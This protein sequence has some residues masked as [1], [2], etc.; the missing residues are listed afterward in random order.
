M[1]EVSI[2]IPTYNEKGNITTLLKRI[3]LTFRK[4][5][6]K[7]EVI[8]VDDNSPD[9]TG[10]IAEKLKKK[11]KNL[12]VLQRKEK[13]GLS[14]A[15]LDGLKIMQGKI[16]GVM[17]ADLSHSPEKI[18][19]MLDV[20]KNE[21]ADF[22]IGS[23]YV[24]GGGIVGWNFYRRGVSKGANF[25]SRLVTSV[26]DS[27]S[28]FFLIKN[29]CIQGIKFNPKGFKICLEFIV[30]AKYNKIIEVPFV[31]KDR[32][33]GKSKLSFKEYYNY[34]K[35]LFGLFCYK[36]PNLGQLI[37]FCMVGGVG[38]IINLVILFLLVEFLNVWY[39]FSAIFA[40]IIAVTNNFILN[41]FWTFESYSKKKSVLT[42]QYTQFFIIS[43]F[44]LGVNLIFLY[45]FVEYF[46]LWYI[47]SQFLAILIALSINFIGNKIWI[48]RKRF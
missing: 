25:L 8:V 45:I 35:H 28:G 32:K 10:L 41:K 4:N 5:K 47:F 24:K 14:S 12:K 17:D 15:I 38:T 26:K 42:K 22:V 6:I 44:A 7:G 16:L 29:K 40:F 46:N 1:N 21:N 36:K 2:I 37:K 30:K 43:L 33:K 27:M 11:Y 18:P 9:G 34:L 31:F 23:R 20:M 39:L 3:F 19:L 13:T 48:F